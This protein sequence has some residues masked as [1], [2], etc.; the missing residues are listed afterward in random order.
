MDEHTK[1]LIEKAKARLAE[2]NAAK[3]AEKQQQES[4]IK[5]ALVTISPE[6]QTSLANIGWQLD[7]SRP[8]NQEQLAAILTGMQGKSFCLIG[9][10]GTGKTS[11]LKGLITSMI[12]NNILP[13]LQPWETTKWLRAGKPGVVLVSFTNMAVRQIAKHFTKEVTTCTIHKLVEM[14]PT[15]YE[16]ELPDGSVVNKVK[17]EPKRNRYNPL[18]RG[19]RTVIVDESSMVSEEHI[20]WILEAIRHD[21]SV[22]WIFLGDLNQI[23]P[24]FGQAILGKK[25]MELPIVELT[26]VYR[27]ALLSPI[28][29]LATKLKNGEAIPVTKKEVIDAGEHGKLTIHPWSGSIP[30]DGN[31]KERGALARACDFAKAAIQQGEL[32][33][34]SDIILCPQNVSFGTVELNASIADWLG[35]QRN[36]FVHEVI[37][38]FNKLYLAEGD[39]VLVN[40]REAIIVHIQRNRSYSGQAPIDPKSYVI[41]RWGGVTKRQE[42]ND[43][44]IIDVGPS[45]EEVT[46]GFDVDAVLADLVHGHKEIED[47]VHQASHQIK[48]RFINGNNPDDWKPSDYKFGDADES[49][50]DFDPEWCECVTLD[51]AA[52]LNDMLF[53]YAVTVHKSQGS[54]WRKVFL[55]LHQSHHAMCYRELIYTAVTRARQELY[56]ICEPD[57]GVKAG[58]LTK[59]SK[60]PRIKGNTLAEKLVSLKEKFAQDA[61]EQQE[62]AKK[63][64][65][66]RA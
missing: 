6:Q 40:K 56:I 38:G 8:W 45:Y 2:I 51:T 62:A 33:V 50:P 26:T 15:F 58:T 11:T 37:A 55:M 21:P 43:P 25:L 24:V 5:N 36:A 52:A 27:Q 46:A 22:Q 28:I 41:D 35:R 63:A 18:P 65:K 54:E 23:P 60:N 19:L 53:A 7:D 14:G 13:I 32:N 30:W 1:R 42:A 9:A 34:N 20:S 16:V 12:R 64:E 44:N 3:E 49:L 29:S 59:A 17:F 4:S 61:K 47:R 10:A 39:K 31:A 66:E 48:V 57:R